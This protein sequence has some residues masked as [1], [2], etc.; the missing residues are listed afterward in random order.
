M[1]K[2]RTVA[3][4]LA[5]LAAVATI[6]ACSNSASKEATPPAPS[7][8][9]ASAPATSS[10]T[11]AHNQAD[12]N[13]THAM[14]P[15]HQQAIEM[16][17]L[18]V[19]KEGIDPRVV[20]LAK[21]IKAA[22][23]PEISTMQGWMSQWGMSA[24][25]GMDHSGMHGSETDSSAPTTSMMPS[26]SMMPGMDHGGMHGSATDSSTPTTS[27]MPGM[28]EMSGMDGMMSQADMDA[29][30]NAQGIQASKLFLTGMIKH[31]QGAL[32]MAQDEIK[33]GQFPDAITMAK[34]ILESQQKEID[35][36][37]QILNSL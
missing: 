37:N 1:N 9:Q 4:G 11:A 6:G 36:M 5:A 16:S 27:M 14:I 24:M 20:E 19:A 30:K 13:F 29:L 3:T 12:M 7:S 2:V 10:H 8:T 25:P 15:H 26:G 17:D 22:Q 34:Q 35:T 18:L 32:T 31:H 28:G 23:G 33:N 21:Q